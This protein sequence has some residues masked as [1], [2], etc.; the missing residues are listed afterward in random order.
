MDFNIKY[1][2]LL[3]F[4]IIIFIFFSVRQFNASNLLNTIIICIII[5]YIFFKD[6]LTIDTVLNYNSKNKSIDNKKTRLS[7]Y[8]EISEIIDKI[9]VCEK[10]DI[11]AY[12]DIKDNIDRFLKLYEK[13]KKNKIFYKYNFDI[14]REIYK[15]IINILE[16]IIICIPANIFYKSEKIETYIDKYN[17]QLRIILYNKLEDLNTINIERINKEGYNINTI[18]DTNILGF[19]ESFKKDDNYRIF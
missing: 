4:I 6:I 12:N 17:Q 2:L 8:P 11:G 1:Y 13:I 3:F 7:K 5:Y 9:K 18:I 15:K 19:D 14:L 10:F 16:N